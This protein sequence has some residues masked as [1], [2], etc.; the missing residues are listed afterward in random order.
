MKVVKYIKTE[1]IE[2]IDADS[3]DDAFEVVDDAIED[4]FK[5][6]NNFFDNLF[7]QKK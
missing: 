1:R 6:I 2:A 4:D 5:S 3:L 7:K